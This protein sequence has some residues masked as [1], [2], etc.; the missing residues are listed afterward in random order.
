MGSWW[1][2]FSAHKLGP[3]MS[4]LYWPAPTSPPPGVP[5]P[6]VHKPNLDP[7]RALSTPLP[8]PRSF[9]STASPPFAVAP[10]L[11]GRNVCQQTLFLKV[12]ASFLCH[13]P[14]RRALSQP[15]E[16]ESSPDAG[17]GSKQAAPRARRGA[18]GRGVVKRRSATTDNRR[19]TRRINQPGS[20]ELFASPLSMLAC[21][22][23]P[24]NCLLPRRA[25]DTRRPQSGPRTSL[26]LTPEC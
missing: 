23:S 6:G 9:C 1:G 15:F 10:G 16:L 11:P 3:S 24:S 25:E 14:C 19:A 22:P 7:K 2:C 8:H 13:L 18:D 17:E 20:P 12:S 4:S 26:L 5:L 21:L